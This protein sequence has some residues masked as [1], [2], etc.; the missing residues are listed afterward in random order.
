MVTFHVETLFP[1]VIDVGVDI[2]VRRIAL[3]LPQ[4]G[5][6]HA[7]DLG[8][9][10][11]IRNVELYHLSGW[12][13]QVLPVPGNIHLW[14]ETPFMSNGPKANQTT[15]IKMAEV[16]GTIKSAGEWAEVTL[17]GQ[18]TWKAQVCGSGKTDKEGVAQWLFDHRPELYPKCRAD[19]DR[20]DAMCIGLYGMM[21]TS[22][23]VQPPVSKKRKKRKPKEAAEVLADLSGFMATVDKIVF[24]G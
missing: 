13:S 11:G 16:V 4:L 5:L 21:R 3:G 8:T 22:G 12:M 10:V 23:Q 1:G 2:G 17:V 7:V 20:I 6:S 14:I 18:S 19:Q 9:K 15:T 24:G